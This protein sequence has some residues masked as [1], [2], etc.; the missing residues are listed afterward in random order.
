MG[1]RSR[2]QVM[3]NEV[4]KIERIGHDTNHK[5]KRKG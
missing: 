3:S 1:G 5:R 2:R 4:W